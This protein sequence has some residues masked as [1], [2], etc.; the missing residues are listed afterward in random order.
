[1]FKDE[2]IVKLWQL[3]DE[4]INANVELRQT[5][6]NMRQTA[7][8]LNQTID[9]LNLTIEALSQTI[10]ELTERV[11]M[12]SRN[13]SKPPS[14]DGLEKPAPKSLRTPSGKKPGGQP[15]HP[16]AYLSVQREPDETVQHM[17]SV[18][19]GCK[20]YELCVS[21]AC[22]GETR[23][24]VDASVIIK[25]T[26]H[27]SLE[28]ENCFV[29]GECQKGE[30]PDEV[31]APVQYGENLQALAVS[32]N[33]I[34]AVSVNRTHE[35]LS[36]VFGIPL[37]AGFISA[38]VSRVANSLAETM[39]R[40]RLSIASYIVDHFD[41]TGTRVDGKNFWVHSASTLLYTLLTISGSR[42]KS[43]MDEGG[44]LPIFTGIAVHDCWSPYWKYEDIIHAICNAHI[45]R[46]LTGVEDNNPNQTWATLFK[47][48][49]LDMKSAKEAAI[50]AGESFL[51][52]EV[53]MGFETRYDE[54]I[55][56]AYEEH[57]LPA[58]PEKKRGRK[59]KGKARALAERLDALKASVCLFA[60]NFS[61]PFDN[62]E[63]ERSVRMIKTKTKV[64]GCFR[65]IKGAQDYL[66]IMSYV[67]TAKKH[68]INPYEAI[69]QAIIG[70]PEF[71]FA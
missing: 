59:K 55:K 28:V 50:A 65:S 26:A 51:S 11:G 9:G 53:L 10:K 23:Q 4:Q 18:C 61:V 62:N 31:R 13:S 40:I 35:I 54:I 71:I 6:E 14:S 70:S 46:E 56:L 20:Y 32:L 69:R 60:C 7:D 30:F 16:G 2:L 49:L 24:V 15:G 47:A 64:S 58:T 3:L 57:P 34:G 38:M 25:V 45:L 44:V 67:G 12:N 43:G 17:P 22:V 41:E 33:T 19:Q 48:L 1:V 27:Q 37:S 68:R 52:E 66:I 21:R 29:F 5:I 63:A 42:G 39:E 36:S 8:A